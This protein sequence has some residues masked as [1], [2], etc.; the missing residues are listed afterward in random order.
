MTLRVTLTSAWLAAALVL[1][2]A[3]SAQPAPGA[4][5]GE[6]H[7]SPAADAGARLPPDKST[8][9]V[10]ELPGRSLHFTA[11]AGSLRLTDAQGTPQAEIAFTAY[12]LDNP[13]Q[14]TRPVTFALNGGPGTASAFL[15]LG[16]V[17]PW[18]LPLGA[19]RTEPSAPAE[20]VPNAETWLDFTDL[21]F[22]D[23]V[24]TGYSRLVGSGD[25]LR[26]HFWSVEG[27]LNSIGEAMRMWLVA[28]HRL[29][30]PKYLLGE[31]Y[32]GFRAPRLAL[33]AAESEGVG[34][35]GL[36]LVS[37]VLDLS[38][39]S[40]AFD[41]LYWVERLPSEVA[42][43]RDVTGPL[44]ADQLA[45]VE[46]Y[47]SGEF[48]QDLL[49][50]ASDQQA[51]ARIATKVAGLTGLDPALVARLGG[52]IDVRTFRREFDRKH[53]RVGSAYDPTISVADP[54][55][56]AADPTLFDAVM[57]GLAAP[58]SAAMVD[59][60]DRQLD[61]RPSGR[62][63]LINEA[64]NR[65]WDWGHG[66]TRPEAFGAL[67]AALAV[68]SHLHVLVTHGMNDL[69][70]P[71]F[72]TKL[73]LRQIPEAAGAGRVRLELYPGGHMFYTRDQSRAEFRRAAEALFGE[74]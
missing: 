49:R 53:G 56:I 15:Q 8:D 38:R 10:L 32:A 69:V 71:Y 46:Q 65:A 30:S 17:G 52:R 57:D 34:F 23:P 29:A 50:G 74:P 5:K 1:G 18:R 67:R 9:H 51:T 73:M 63:R 59:L 54:Y 41:P 21:V 36:I 4:G 26:R 6:P 31:S 62:Y 24:G 37:P 11:T 3:A 43:A 48:L 61:W 12:L 7:S 68:D 22:I 16:A 19:D 25:E 45:D 47:A 14:R 40:T 2:V 20:L 55:P 27:D 58:L 42:A 66:P 60:Y 44:A 13:D 35:N 64:A 72:E 28:N 39:G 70:A 33:S